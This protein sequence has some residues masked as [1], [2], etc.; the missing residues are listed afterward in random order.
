MRVKARSV[1]HEVEQQLAFETVTYQPA[2][3]LVLARRD[4]TWHLEA[5]RRISQ[6]PDLAAQFLQVRIAKSRVVEDEVFHESA[7]AEVVAA[8]SFVN[9]ACQAVGLGPELIERADLIRQQPVAVAGEPQSLV[10]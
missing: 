4:Q 8:G 3:A 7:I 1:A 10:G 6:E 5:G 9:S 2:F